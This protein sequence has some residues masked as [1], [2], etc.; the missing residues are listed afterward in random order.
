MVLGDVGFSRGRHYWE[1]SIEKYEGNPDPAFGVA[2][3]NVAKDVILGR[4]ERAWSVY[5]DSNRSW[6]QH[7]NEHLFRSEGG[8]EAGSTVGLL[9]DL[10]ENTLTF[11]C[12]GEKRGPV[13]FPSLANA[14]V[15][16]P[17]FSLNRN[18]STILQTGLEPS[19]VEA[20]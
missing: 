17:A 20:F 5:V 3:E 14:D 8:I 11:Y 13:A 12:N 16:Y 6:F 15:V 9:L 4:D 1:V 19:D 2:L 18:V 10:D 7:N